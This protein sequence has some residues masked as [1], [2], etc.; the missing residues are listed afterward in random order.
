MGMPI[1]H[2]H[3]EIALAL[4][5]AA[6]NRRIA[7]LDRKRGRP[8]LIAQDIGAARYFLAKAN[9]INEYLRKGL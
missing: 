6:Y 8:I 9:R 2:L 5:D 1:G 4:T 3:R 7:A